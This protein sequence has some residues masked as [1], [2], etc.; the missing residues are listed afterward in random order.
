MR[1]SSTAVLAALCLGGVAMALYGSPIEAQSAAHGRIC[2]SIVPVLNPRDA[3]LTILSTEPIGRADGV[4]VTYDM[5]APGAPRPRAR[6][7]VCAFTKRAQGSEEL[8]MVASDG[9]VLGVPRL[10]FLKRYYLR[11]RDAESA[12]AALQQAPAAGKELQRPKRQP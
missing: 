5:V 8:L 1:P 3:K 9:R 12:E 2:R 10:T 7:L 6:R 11:S 4:V